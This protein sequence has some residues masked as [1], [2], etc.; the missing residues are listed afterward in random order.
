MPWRCDTLSDTRH[1]LQERKL[2]AADCPL[3]SITIHKGRKKTS[4]AWG[5]RAVC[6]AAICNGDLS[7]QFHI[8][9]RKGKANVPC[10]LQHEQHVMHQ[11]Y[12]TVCL[13]SFFCEG[14]DY[15][16]ECSNV[17]AS[18][19]IHKNMS[20]KLKS[21]WNI[22]VLGSESNRLK[23]VYMATANPLNVVRKFS[24]KNSVGSD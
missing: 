7:Q 11:T 21:C 12:I 17:R 20:Q 9:G 24:P 22:A 10:F 4:L 15:R 1:A 2:I 16:D 13:V 3:Q 14:W 23:Y 6:K 18:F 19:E 5:V 8:K